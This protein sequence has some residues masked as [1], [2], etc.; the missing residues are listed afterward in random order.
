M[1]RIFSTSKTNRK[2]TNRKKTNRKKINRKK[3]NRRKTNRR[4]TNRRKTNRKKTNKRGGDSG[5][6]EKNTQEIINKIIHDT[7]SDTLDSSSFSTLVKQHLGGAKPLGFQITKEELES[8][9]SELQNKPHPQFLTKL[10][11]L[12]SQ[13]VEYRAM[14]HTYFDIKG[15][16]DKTADFITGFEMDNLRERINEISSEL[17]DAFTPT[18]NKQPLKTG[19]GSRSSVAG[20]PD[21]PICF[22]YVSPSDG[23]IISHVN[24]EGVTLTHPHIFHRECLARAIGGDS[25]S[26]SG[27]CP[28]CRETMTLLEIETSLE[29]GL[30][31]IKEFYG[32]IKLPLMVI[33]ATIIVVYIS[34]NTDSAPALYEF[35]KIL[36]CICFGIFDAC[37]WAARTIAIAE[38]EPDASDPPPSLFQNFCS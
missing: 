26:E 7:N 25:G 18:E 8:K 3:T 23:H 28:M 38:G 21:C 30:R 5:A 4:K 20:A 2:K 33:M 10:T 29:C 35:L 15:K 37:I 1:K 11:N 32:N 16:K 6:P 19:G 14:L 9:V 27:P 36:L 34:L 22:E 13:L 17:Q 31:K 12:T 24:S